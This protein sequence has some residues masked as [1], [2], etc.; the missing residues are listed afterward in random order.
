MESRDVVRQV[1]VY[2]WQGRNNVG[3]TLS[4]PI[5]EHLLNCPVKLVKRWARGKLVA[6]GS[7]LWAARK[8]DV[9]WGTGGLTKRFYR[10]P[11][12]KFL[13]VR[14]PLTRQCI[15]TRYNIPE[16]YGDPALLLPLIYSPQIKK[17]YEVGVV[18]HW[19]DENSA[20]QQHQGGKLISTSLPW[21]HFIDEIVN[22]EKIISSS[23]HGIIIAEA[24]GIPATWAIW[25][26]DMM[27]QAFKFQ[28]YMLGTGREIIL[29]FVELKPII[30][31][32]GI[33]DKLVKAL[34]N[35]YELLH[36]CGVKPR[37][38]KAYTPPN[39]TGC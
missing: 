21:R 22:C 36:D 28:D 37:H 25:N 2:Q 4:K 32:K 13:A 5:I 35:H 12:V 11:G 17:Q 24:Y 20:Y 15:R 10:L 6:C 39:P 16:V 29:P 30:D 14:G 9:V 26:P 1:N 18:P 31:L 27:K 33:Q 8:G 7:I 34:R 19:I 3:D 23:L 38:Y